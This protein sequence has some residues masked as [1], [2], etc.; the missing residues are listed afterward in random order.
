MPQ[1]TQTRNELAQEGGPVG[2]GGAGCVV[3]ALNASGRHL[4]QVELVLLQGELGQVLGKVRTRQP[5]EEDEEEGERKGEIEKDFVGSG[6]H[7]VQTRQ[8]PCRHPQHRP[9]Q[10]HKQ[11]EFGQPVAAGAPQPLV[12]KGQPGGGDAANG[13]GQDAQPGQRP[14]NLRSQLGNIEAQEGQ[15]NRRDA[16]HQHYDQKWAQQG[17]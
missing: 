11:R 2:L 13:P 10:Q 12:G 16:D 1:P 15:G 9:R 4:G 7:G 5:G 6:E 3:D 8:A 14:E 17:A